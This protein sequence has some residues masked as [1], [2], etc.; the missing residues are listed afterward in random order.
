MKKP[1]SRRDFVKTSALAAAALPALV[2]AESG[3]A[4]PAVQPPVAMTVQRETLPMGRIGNVEFSRLMLGGNL[5]SGHA[6]ARDLR[7]VA[8]LMRRYNTEARIAETLE[9]AEANGINVINTW[10]MDDNSH[11]FKHWK[12]GGKMK[13]IAQARLDG[14]GGYS[15]FRRAVDEGASGVHITGDNAEGLLAQGKFDKVAESVELI[16]SMKRVAGVAAHDFRVVIECEKRKLDV[17]FYQA[18]FHSHDYFSGPRPGDT[19]ALGAND[20]YWCVN[21]NLA[22]EF[23]AKVQKPWIAFKILAAGALPPRSAFPYAINNGADFILVGMFDWQIE[24]N[25]KLAKRVIDAT[26]RSTTTRTRP[27]YGVAT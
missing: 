8:T 4:T 20:N 6:H 11:I 19:E 12:R 22:V 24:E 17:D 1:V 9:T 5:I 16:R 3:T 26:S 10:V 21:P 18:T 15:Q 27:W 25:A 14:N 2:R 23:M 13:W 7:Y